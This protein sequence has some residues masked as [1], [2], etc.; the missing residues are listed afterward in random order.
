MRD[1]MCLL[2]V[3][4]ACARGGTGPVPIAYDK[5]ACAYCHM[6]IGDP[7]FAAQLVTDDGGA[8]NFDDPGCL[9]RFIAEQHPRARAIWFR[10]SQR[11]RWLPAAEVGFVHAASTPMG[12][13][14]A[15]VDR[16]TPGAL[17]YDEAS[18]R[19]AHA[20]RPTP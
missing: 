20:P 17:S 19:I 1:A 14:L 2:L 13:Q 18:A 15:A 3:V 16:G 9:L 5:E 8:I 11:D 6:L 7:R 12:W 4:V 10:D